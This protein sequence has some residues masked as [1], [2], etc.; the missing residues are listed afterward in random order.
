MLV[1]KITCL[2][3]L[4]SFMLSAQEIQKNDNVILSGYNAHMSTAPSWEDD[5]FFDAVKKLNSNTFRYPGGSN[6]FYWNWRT[7]WTYS[8]KE[9]YSVLKKTDFKYQ[10]QEIVS[11]EQLAILS[12]SERQKTHFGD[13]FTDI[14][15]LMLELKR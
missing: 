7:G 2:F 13:N 15:I 6:S 1:P 8:Y 11:P 14:T 12:K 5:L 3:F 9:M 10:G 4:L